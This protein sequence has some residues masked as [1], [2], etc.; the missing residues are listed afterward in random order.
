[1]GSCSKGSGGGGRTTEK[2]WVECR[3]MGVEVCTE[4]GQIR[5][6]I[7][8]SSHCFSQFHRS[9][10]CEVFIERCYFTATS[11]QK[12]LVMQVNKFILTLH[13]QIGIQIHVDTGSQESITE[14]CSYKNIVSIW[15][16]LHS[17]V[18]LCILSPKLVS[19]SKWKLSTLLMLF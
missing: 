16:V 14:R 3:T 9:K 19:L 5:I 10:C 2:D 4:M 18:C 12:H 13:F 8:K 15:F 11:Q 6:C 17:N 7:Y 1:M